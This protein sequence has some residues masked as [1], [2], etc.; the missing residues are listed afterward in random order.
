MENTSFKD[1]FKLIASPD[2]T[3]LI[4]IRTVAEK[5]STVSNFKTFMASYQKSLKKGELSK[6]N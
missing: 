5:V 1:A 4:D 2:S 3:G 6:I